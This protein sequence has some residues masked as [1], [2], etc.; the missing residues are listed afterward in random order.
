MTMYL[1]KVKKPC[2]IA[3]RERSDDMQEKQQYKHQGQW[4]SRGGDAL[5]T[6]D[7]PAAFSEDHGEAGC[8]PAAH[9]G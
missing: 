8:R 7:S 2:T 6:R 5:G 4:R 9:G 3:A 1:R